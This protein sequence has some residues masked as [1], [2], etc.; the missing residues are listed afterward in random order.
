MSR[1]SVRTYRYI[2]TTSS[3]PQFADLGLVEVTFNVFDV[4]LLQC[5]PQGKD[6]GRMVA[7]RETPLMSGNVSTLFMIYEGSRV[8]FLHPSAEQG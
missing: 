6:R 5:E 1:R 3:E 2:R 4:F 8:L 7:S